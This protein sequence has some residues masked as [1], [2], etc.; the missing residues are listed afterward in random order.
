MRNKVSKGNKY[1]NLTVLN[2]LDDFHIE[3][4]GKK[5]KKV[6]VKCEC[7]FQ[8]EMIALHLTRGGQKCSKC[9]FITDSIVTIGEIYD[10]LTIIDFSLKNNR[11]VAV[12]KCECGN[13]IT[14]RPES[15]IKNKTNNCGCDH[16]GSWKGFGEISKTDINR[17][18]ANA[19]KRNITY[20]LSIEYLW[21]LYKS[22]NGLCA[23]SKLPIVFS[24]KTTDLNTASLD[25][26]DSNI[27]YIEGNVQWTHKDVNKMKMD[28]TE[29]RFIE[30]CKI[31][32]NLN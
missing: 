2:V 8:F 11:K 25:R 17:I 7:G 3:P 15:L 14:Q 23:L 9:R 24:K 21:D 13:I 1:N 32:S 26:I 22:Q 19:K 30:L 20:D 29:L 6:L 31:I 10:K 16:R 28:F 12:C 4:S 27:G 18:L 5:R